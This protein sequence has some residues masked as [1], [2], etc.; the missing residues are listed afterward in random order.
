[1]K[2][3]NFLGSAIIGLIFFLSGCDNDEACLSN[4]NS[5]QVKMYSAWSEDDRDS[6][7][8]NVSLVGIDRTDS[9][10][11]DQ[12]LSE[13]FMPLDFESDT[14]TFVLSAQTLKDTISFV[15]SS[16]LDFISG[17]C[18]Y[19]FSF[20]IDT[21]MHTDAFIDSAAIEHPFIEYGESVENIKLY[22]Y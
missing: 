19:I 11:S 14:T 21:F 2:V 13:L 18:G 8:S 15:H 16:E 12:T 22:I 1:M 9:V 7:L 5:A 17:E 3:V 20:E 4:Q 10:Y 6:T